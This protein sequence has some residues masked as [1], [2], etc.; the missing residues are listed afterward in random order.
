[1]SPTSSS[2]LSVEFASPSPSPIVLSQNLLK[3]LI[4]VQEKEIVLEYGVAWG[5]VRALW[6]VLEWWR[7]K[8]SLAEREG[9]QVEGEEA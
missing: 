9:R 4:V 2:L 8:K 1:M 3:K 7:D 6:F 5:E